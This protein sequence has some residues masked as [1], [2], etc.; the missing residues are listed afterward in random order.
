MEIN[1][2]LDIIS[3]AGV[4]GIL[5]IILAGGLR[6]WW[7]FG[8][9]YRATIEERNEWKQIALRGVNLAE[10]GVAKDEITRN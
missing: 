7:V 1:D 9:L 10:K 6:Q 4:V 8:W 3:Q 5:V 2:I